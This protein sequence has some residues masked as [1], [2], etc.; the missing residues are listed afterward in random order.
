MPCVFHFGQ[1]AKDLV[2]ENVLCVTLS[3]KV[4]LQTFLGHIITNLE[5]QSTEC[6]K[7]HRPKIPLK[8]IENLRF[9]GPACNL[10]AKQTEEY[11]IDHKVPW[12]LVQQHEQNNLQVLCLDCHRKKTRKDLALIRI[13]QRLPAKSLQSLIVCFECHSFCSTYFEHVHQATFQCF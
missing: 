8:W 10:C 12:C 13:L 4:I 9:Q 3:L 1:S 2:K 7:A 11:D 5:M 6:Q